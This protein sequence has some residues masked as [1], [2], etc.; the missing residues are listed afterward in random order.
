M[1]RR[2]FLRTT[3]GT[4]TAS[5][6]AGCSTLSRGFGGD[7]ATTDPSSDETKP[8]L[9]TVLVKNEADDTKRIG[10]EVV[11]N[12]GNRFHSGYKPLK[13]SKNR[14]Y[15]RDWPDEPGEYSVV[16][17]VP[18]DGTYDLVTFSTTDP[19]TDEGQRWQ[20]DLK[21]IFHIEEDGKITNEIVEVSE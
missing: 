17:H 4:F 5:V 14:K 7:S 3:A 16:L 20:R 11:Q 10:V 1:N 12:H 18:T 21:V 8:V 2:T 15:S 19:T 6:L 13:P 9:Q